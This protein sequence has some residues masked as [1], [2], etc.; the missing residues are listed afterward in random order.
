MSE[1]TNK[2]SGDDL[3]PL[4]EKMIS[5]AFS[6]VQKNKATSIAELIG[7]QTIAILET[8]LRIKDGAKR[9]H[10]QASQP[11]EGGDTEGTVAFSQDEAEDKA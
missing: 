11:S 3:M 1:K 8:Y 4:A 5:F 7:H 9:V 2:P 10:N 6:E